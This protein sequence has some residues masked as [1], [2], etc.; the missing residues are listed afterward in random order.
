[1]ITQHLH[2]NLEKPF[3]ERTSEPEIIV[4][5]GDSFTLPCRVHGL[6]PP[7]VI[8]KVDDAPVPKTA[9]GLT[10]DVS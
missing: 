5:T 9:F 2:D 10:V 6:P 3:I 4:K 7:T 8:W 1:M